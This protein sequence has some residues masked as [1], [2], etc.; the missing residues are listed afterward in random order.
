MASRRFVAYYV[1]TRRTDLPYSG[2]AKNIA[3]EV[4]ALTGNVFTAIASWQTENGK[5]ILVV[6]VVVGVNRDLKVR[7]RH[8]ATPNHH[9]V[10]WQLT[11]CRCLILGH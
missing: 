2:L 10:R 1:V 4:G 7:E 11:A 3:I 9:S 6:M 8:I 5:C